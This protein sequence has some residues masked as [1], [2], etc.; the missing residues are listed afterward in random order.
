V[1]ESSRRHTSEVGST[2]TKV[3]EAMPKHKFNDDL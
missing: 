3:H 2:Q 1:E